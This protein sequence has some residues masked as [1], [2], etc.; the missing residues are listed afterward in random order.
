MKKL[1]LVPSIV[2]S[3]ALFSSCTITTSP[4]VPAT[5]YTEY[6]TGYTGYTVN[7]A[8][9]AGNDD[10]GDGTYVG[11]GGWASSFYAPGYRY[12][13]RGYSARR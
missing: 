12:G 5:G 3:A 2:F 1:I 10:I 9:G 7:Y 6:N 8:Y 4:S 13:Y 11:Y